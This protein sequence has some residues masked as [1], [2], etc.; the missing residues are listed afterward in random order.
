MVASGPSTLARA[1]NRE[2]VNF[3]MAALLG[4]H[5][6]G[7]RYGESIILQLPDGGVGVIDSFAPRRG[8]HPVIAFLKS[9]FPS[10]TNLSFFAVTHPHADHCFRAAELLNSYPSREAWIFQPFPAGQ[11]QDYYKALQNLQQTERVEAAL[12]LPVGSVALSLLQLENRIEKLRQTG[13]NFRYFS[14]PRNFT[15]CGERLNLHFLTPGDGCQNDYAVAVAKAAKAIFSDGPA[16]TAKD[17]LPKP[18]HNL[19]SGALLIEFGKTRALLMSDAEGPRW[20]AWL[21]SPAPEE[22]RKPI[23]FIK[24]SHHGSFNGYL[25]RLYD[26]IGD[27]QTTIAVMTPFAMGKEPLPTAEGVKSVRLHV[28]DLYCTNRTAAI[29]STELTW[30]PVTTAPIPNLPATW[31]SMIRRKRTLARLLVPESG[32]PASAGHPPAMPPQWAIDAHAHPPLWRLI[33][34]QHRLPIPSAST[35]ASHTFSI[36]YDDKGNLLDLQVGADVGRLMH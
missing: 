24:A 21:D 33:H 23:H 18:D 14:W 12:G 4:I 9:R 7:P 34:P 28:R 10:L 22:L 30:E 8:S 2:T 11:V 20:D 25:K 27:P 19:A 3:A 15:L 6:I 35:V 5:V 13:L 16:L 26:I 17:Q 32:V 36:Y 31:A 1:F 29:K